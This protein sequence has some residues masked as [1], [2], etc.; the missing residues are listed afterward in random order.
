ML[1]AVQ[2]YESEEY[3][4]K[5]VDMGQYNIQWNQEKK[6]LLKIDLHL[7]PVCAL[8]IFISLLDQ[9]N[10]FTAEFDKMQSFIGL[11][12]SQFNHC[13]MICIVTYAVFAVPSCLGLI[14]TSPSSWL[15]TIISCW[16]VVMTTMGIIH[17]FTGLFWSRFF[18]GVFEA[19]MLPGVSF[20]LS[21]W[22]KKNEL[23][24]RQAL[25]T[26]LAVSA[27]AFGG[28][29]SWTILMMTGVGG[30]E[31]WR[32]VF[33]IEGSL[34]VVVGGF[35]YMIMCNY[36]DTSD[37][38]SYSEKKI[39]N[40]RVLAAEGWNME[41]FEDNEDDEYEGEE[42]EIMQLFKRY[43]WNGLEGSLIDWQVWFHTMIYIAISVAKYSINILLPRILGS[44]NFTEEKI[45]LISIP[46][47]TSSSICSILVAIASDK[48]AAR[49]PA[50]VLSFVMIIAGF[51]VI[52]I[53][54]V[55]D[56]RGSVAYSGMFLASIGV[57]TAIPAS[58]TWLSNNTLCQAK[59][60][61]AL[62]LQIGLGELGGVVATYIYINSNT[63]KSFAHGMIIIIAFSGLILV[64]LLSFIYLKT[65]RK[66]IKICTSVIAERLPNMDLALVGDKN[67][68]F[69]YMN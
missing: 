6:L 4:T 26:G 36:P 7:I 18:L 65:N 21:I 64:I 22:Y 58:V 32:W 14:K 10:I 41:E 43:K 63:S 15:S 11:E 55:H 45:K 28:L 34:S 44:M 19:G 61:F 8:F 13:I 37:L 52:M 48:V 5:P 59:R 69:R 17:D 66:R 38:L 51:I 42:S 12:G 1:E 16:G 29:L 3:D 23:Q 31:G 49:S 9:G 2:I 35:G 27:N 39:M 24:F 53:S 25:L 62:A 46:V 57:Y 56:T 30:L 68:F 67:V 20:V 33:I 54:E 60:L 40:K 47:F 50:L